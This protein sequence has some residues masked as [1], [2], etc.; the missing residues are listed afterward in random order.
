MNKDLE[1]IKV[2]VFGEEIGILAYEPNTGISYFQYNE[3]F[4]NKQIYKNIFPFGIKRVQQVQIFKGLNNRT[5]KGL[6]AAFADSLPDDFG[7][8]IYQ[9]WIKSHELTTKELT[10]IHQLAYMGNRGMGAL[11]YFPGKFIESS[12]EIN[13]NDIAEILKEVIDKKEGAEELKLS[14]FAL[15][16]IFKLGSSAGGARPKVIVSE[17][18][19]TGVLVPGD[20]VY[21]EDY[22]HYLVKLDIRNEVDDYNRA[23]VEYAYYEMAKKSGIKMMAT[24]L[25]EN[26]HFATERYDRVN[27]EKVHVLTATGISGLDFREADPSSYETV[28]FIAN[29]LN[30]P[31]SD[32]DSIFRRMVFNYV[33]HNTDDHLKN[34]SFMYDRN[35]D[36]WRITPAYDL[37]YSLDALN[38]W[39]G[40]VHALSLNGKR[41]GIEL[42]DLLNI[43]QEYSVSSPKLII[44]QIENASKEWKSTADALGIPF[45]VA[46]SINEDFCYFLNN[47]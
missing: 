5:F 43:A 24:K 41:K 29:F 37:N 19:E 40:A 31:S 12:G 11:E 16:N 28:F 36:S 3:V 8:K 25:I 14:D 35:L 1:N 17:N 32:I 46:D 26:R 45:K 23:L 34:H 44:E 47:I 18:K 9:E 22:K 4:L 6:P 10:P 7:N 33:F 20:L 38:K 13:L 21:S 42:Q 27:G 39:A 15:L 30:V 2:F